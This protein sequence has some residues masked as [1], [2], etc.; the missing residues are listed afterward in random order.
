MASIYVFALIVCVCFW[1]CVSFLALGVWLTEAGEP[2]HRTHFVAFV[3]FVGSSNCVSC[4]V[5][6]Q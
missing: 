6:W 5:K 2:D 4:H 3:V 1:Q